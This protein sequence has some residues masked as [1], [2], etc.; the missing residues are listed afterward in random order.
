MV[1]LIL[2]IQ[3]LL[4]ENTPEGLLA[5]FWDIPLSQEGDMDNEFLGVVVPMAALLLSSWSIWAQE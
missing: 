3:Q 1:G 2:Q 5:D 4:Q